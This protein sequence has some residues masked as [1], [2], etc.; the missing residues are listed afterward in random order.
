MVRKYGQNNRPPAS[1]HLQYQTRVNNS[2][3]YKTL[4]Y[5]IKTISKFEALKIFVFN[6]RV[7]FKVLIKSGRIFVIL[8][9]WQ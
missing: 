9:K 6:R 5:D 2:F 8:H 7:L 4:L 1:D 3:S